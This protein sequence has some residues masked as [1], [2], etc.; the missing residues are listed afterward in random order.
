MKQSIFGGLTL[1]ILAMA[2][3][4]SAQEGYTD[5]PFLPG[6]KWH[7][8]DKFRPRPKVVAPRPY[9]GL[10]IPAPADAKVLFDGKDTSQWTQ[11]WKLE[12]G[13]MLVTNA[14]G[15]NK[16][17]ESFTDC[18]LHLEFATPSPVTGNGQS[19]GNSGVFFMDR[20]EI[21]VLDSYNSDSYADGL[22]GSV[23]GQ[24]PPLVNAARKPGEWQTYDIFFTAPKFTAD[25][26]VET[27]AYVTVILNGV[28]VQNHA[29][30]LGPCTYRGL[31]VY[32]AHGPAPIRL[33][34]HGDPGPTTRFRNI[35]IRPLKPV[36]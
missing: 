22:V 33:Q 15:D 26:K 11:P 7:V 31:P 12:D 4:A 32:S 29:E 24:H 2:T 1:L 10:P 3:N 28:L 36:E 35:W 30:I 19:R 23:Y 27:P 13:A 21:Q 25:G 18:Q 17:K 5:T 34:S 14:L 20:Y 6:N 8:H 16:T 9:D